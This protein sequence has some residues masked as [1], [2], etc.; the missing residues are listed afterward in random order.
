MLACSVPMFTGM[1]CT[2]SQQTLTFNTLA[3]TEDA[4]TKA[5]SAYMSLVL[6]GQIPTN[7]VHAV[8]DYMREFQTIEVLAI[9]AAAGN[10][11]AIAGPEVTAASVKVLNAVN[12]DK[13][14]AGVK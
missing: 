6:Q 2:P 8:S 13:Q 14:K 11:N 7:N 9:T 10:T 12:A 3:T 5:Y 4:T 1:T